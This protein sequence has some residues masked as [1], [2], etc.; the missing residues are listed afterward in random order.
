MSPHVLAT[1]QAVR[2]TTRA[3]VA[4]YSSPRCPLI[5][6]DTARESDYFDALTLVKRSLAF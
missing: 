4:Y 2:A 6:Q 3:K 1:L 5:L